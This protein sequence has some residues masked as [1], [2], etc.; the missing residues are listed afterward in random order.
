[1][2]QSASGLKEDLQNKKG[3]A[4][5]YLYWPFEKMPKFFPLEKIRLGLWSSELHIED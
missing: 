2:S 4:K 5:D 1:M 3:P